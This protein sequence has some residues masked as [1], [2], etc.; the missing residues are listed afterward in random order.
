MPHNSRQLSERFE[1]SEDIKRIETL[2]WRTD[3]QDFDELCAFVMTY[4][5]DK[6]KL[7]IE[8]ITSA[9]GTDNLRLEIRKAAEGF[10]ERDISLAAFVT[11]R[12]HCFVAAKL[13]GG[14]Q[15]R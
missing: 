4:L 8:Q 1:W 2:N 5:S 10:T 6:L 11:I 12:L 14:R 15:H 7:S 3:A 13:R 9:V